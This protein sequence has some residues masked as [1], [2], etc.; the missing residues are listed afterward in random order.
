MAVCISYV[1]FLFLKPVHRVF[2]RAGI[3][4]RR[5]MERFM[6]KEHSAESE[7]LYVKTEELQAGAK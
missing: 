3:R 4:S 5:F 7:L 6:G 1:C 2:Y